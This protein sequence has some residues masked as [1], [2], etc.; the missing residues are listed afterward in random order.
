MTNSILNKIRLIKELSSNLHNQHFE[1]LLI[2]RNKYL[3]NKNFVTEIQWFA[4]VNEIALRIL[5]L[6]YFDSQLLAGLLLAE[7]QII[8]MKTGEGKT[9]AATL[10]LS[11]KALSKKGAHLVTTNEYLAERDQKFTN[12]LYNALG[13]HSRCIKSTYSSAQK[14]ENYLADITYTSSTELIFD[15]LNDHFLSNSSGNILRPL[16]Y[17]L[18]DEADLILID[19]IEIPFILSNSYSIN[20]FSNLIEAKKIAEELIEK[21]KV[22]T[23][24]KYK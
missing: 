14:R 17:A 6:R 8:E 4:L 7:G 10:C 21:I 22:T 20:N 16:F 23:N 11:Y 9:L 15:Y 3:Q 18:I 19:N 24:T 13:L 12:I 5:G 1:D 2:L